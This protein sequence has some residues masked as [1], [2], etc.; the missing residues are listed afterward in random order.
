MRQHG[1]GARP[2]GDGARP[3]GRLHEDGLI[4]ALKDAS[5]DLSR[6]PRLLRLCG[7]ELVQLSGDDATALAHLAMGGR[8]CVS[9]TANVAPALCS[10]L[11]AAFAVRDMA[12]AATL[13]DLLAPLDAALFAEA[14]P[15]AVKA[16][17]GLLG[18]CEPHPRLPLTRAEPG[19]L[20]RLRAALGPL[21]EREEALARSLSARAGM[22]QV[23]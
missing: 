16:A 3:D 13:R 4:Q 22:R 9:V 14:N 15:I 8:G 6:P 20:A 11:Q 23:A 2:L 18:L 7:P 19:T 1:G 17:L 5:G 10:A 21:M 12:F